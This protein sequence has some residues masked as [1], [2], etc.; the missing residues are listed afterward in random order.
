[1]TII[2]EVKELMQRLEVERDALRLKL[3]LAG[4]DCRDEWQTVQS[5]YEHLKSR[6]NEASSEVQELTDDTWQ[7]LRTL[8]EEVAEAFRCLRKEL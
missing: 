8:G 7:G 4:M 6:V 3:H 1:M 2:N 5:R